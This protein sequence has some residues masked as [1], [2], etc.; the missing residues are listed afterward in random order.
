[1]R[2]VPQ[3]LSMS[4]VTIV[5]SKETVDT[6]GERQEPILSLKAVIIRYKD[7][8]AAQLLYNRLARLGAT[9]HTS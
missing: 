2:L 9:H 4:L 8:Q 5:G 7:A 3:P 1:M 6:E